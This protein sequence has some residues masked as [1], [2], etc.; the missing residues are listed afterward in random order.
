MKLSILI[1]TI[2]Q[3]EDR[4]KQLLEVLRPQMKDVEILAYWNNG[5]K[6]LWEIR[7]A[8]VEEAKGEYISFID[9]DDSV[10]DYYVEEILK[11]IAEKP[12]YVGWRMQLWENG[13]KAKPTFHSVKYT[14]WSEDDRGWY[15]GISHLNPIQRDIALQVSFETIPGEAEDQPWTKKIAPLVKTEAYIDREMYWYIHSTADSVWRGDVKTYNPY[16][17]PIIKLKGFRW[18]PLSNKHYIPGAR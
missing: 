9:D 4:F 5:E 13:E 14:E 7:Q 12:D 11:A 6:P 16:D 1:A 2:G 8:L 3:R 18:H 15:R 10:P 17:R